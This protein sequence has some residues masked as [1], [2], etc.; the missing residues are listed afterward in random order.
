MK[1]R[2]AS[3]ILLP[4]TKTGSRFPCT[5]LMKEDTKQKIKPAARCRIRYGKNLEILF[6]QMSP[7]IGFCRRAGF[8]LVCVLNRFLRGKLF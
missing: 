6:I 7:R 1:S 5:E 8:V 2:S 4:V 3:R